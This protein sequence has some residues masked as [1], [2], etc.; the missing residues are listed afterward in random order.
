MS[1]TVEGTEPSGD[2]TVTDWAATHDVL[3]SILPFAYRDS[4]PVAM[5]RTFAAE[6]DALPRTAATFKVSDLIGDADE[7]ARTFG[8]DQHVETHLA[9]CGA[10]QC[11]QT[12][13]GKRYSNPN[14]IHG[15]VHRDSWGT[16]AERVAFAERMARLGAVPLDAVGRHFGLSR[17]GISD[18]LRAEGFTWNAERQAGKAR[19]ACSVE[20]IAAWTD[21]DYT[22]ILRPIGVDYRAFRYWRSTYV[23]DDFEPPADPTT[24]AGVKRWRPAQIDG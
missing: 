19:L 21:W 15:S 16:P 17:T 7:F 10:F 24:A 3:P 6:I 5:L 12:S 8:A 22:E 18:A 2:T 23:D 14:Y 4:N 9:L 20:T 11:D 1:K 13:T